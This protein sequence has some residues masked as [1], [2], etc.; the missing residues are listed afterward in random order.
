[1]GRGWRPILVGAAVVLGTFALAKAHPFEPSAPS[2]SSAATGD[3]N[4]RRASSS[5]AS[6]RAATARRGRVEESAR[7]SLEPAS[8]RPP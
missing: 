4:P 7:R 1:M 6:A 2:T 5:S 8:T 3:C